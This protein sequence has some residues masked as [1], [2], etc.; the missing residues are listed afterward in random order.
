VQNDCVKLDNV[1]VCG[2]RGWSAD[3]KTEDGKRLFARELL[4]IELSLAS[5]EKIRT[6]GDR[7]IFMIHYPPFNSRFEDNEVTALFEKYNVDAVVYGHLHGRDCRAQKL[8]NKH[9]IPYY[10]TSCDQIK[11][12]AVRIEL[13]RDFPKI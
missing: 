1:I 9:G 2:S 6:D 3:D 12:K 10:L 4:R 8:L 11:N 5:M 7:V 13:G